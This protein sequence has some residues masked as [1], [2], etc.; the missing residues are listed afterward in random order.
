MEYDGSWNWEVDL[1]HEEEQLHNFFHLLR[2]CD[3]QNRTV[4]FQFLENKIHDYCNTMGRN[5]LEAQYFDLHNLPDIIVR[6]INKGMFFNGQEIIESFFKE[7]FSVHHYLAMQNFQKVFPN[8]YDSFYKNNYYKVKSSLRNIILDEIEFLEDTCMEYQLDMFIDSIPDILHEFGL[9]Y[10]KSFEA[11]IYELCG[12]TPQLQ[13]SKFRS[14]K[15]LYREIDQEKQSFENVKENA[16]N[17][18]FGP[19][20][21]WLEEQEIA[22]LISN[23]YINPMLKAELMKVLDRTSSQYVYD[24]LQTEAS[25]NLLMAALNESCQ[26]LP[27]LESHL[28]MIILRHLVQGD[29]ELLIKLV[30][31][32]AESFMMIMYRE[33]PV[34]RVDQF[35]SSDIY[36]HYLVD[37]ELLRE[38]V[39]T[40]LFLQDELWI[41]FIHLPCFI[42]CYAFIL[43]FDYMDE[44]VIQANQEAWRDI[45]GDNSAK[46]KYAIKE[47]GRI[48][49]SIYYMEYGVYNFKRNDWESRMYRVFEELNPFDFNQFYVYPRIKEYLTIIG[50]KNDERKVLNHL[51]LCKIKFEYTRSGNPY[52]SMYEVTDELHMIDCLDIAKGWD[53]Y[54]EKIPKAKWKQLQLNEDI[55]KR[56]NDN[57]TLLVYKITDIELLK[58]LGIYSEILKFINKIESVSARFSNSDY[59]TIERDSYF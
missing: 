30:G 7:A 42:F 45:W 36:A 26:Q 19:D 23:S 53:P 15:S 13:T 9:R 3:C 56:D 54:P 49:S 31:F 34:I 16:R 40:H 10:T 11:K 18:L 50:N 59:S 22:D 25:T 6:C 17:W 20:E 1:Y 12:T 51:S 32:C 48:D 2:F 47:N 24:F 14:K 28:H 4:L 29:Q 27:R 57:W 8:E 41:R 39:F 33:E 55:C 44:Q 58:E 37:N 21:V 35:E 38:I 46:L 5:N 43:C 52:S